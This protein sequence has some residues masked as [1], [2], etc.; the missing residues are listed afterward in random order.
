MIGGVIM[1]I[2]VQITLII[3]VTIIVLGWMGGDNE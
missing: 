3:C 2:P 1:A